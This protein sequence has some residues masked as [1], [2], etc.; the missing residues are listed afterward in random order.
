MY[1][2]VYTHYWLA[3]QSFPLKYLR[4]ITNDSL[5]SIFWLQLLS[6]LKLCLTGTF[7]PLPLLPAGLYPIHH[8]LTLQLRTGHCFSLL[9]STLQDT[10]FSGW[11]SL[12]CVTSYLLFSISLLPPLWHV[13]IRG[14]CVGSATSVVDDSHVLGVSLALVHRALWAHRDS[15]E[16]SVLTDL[17]NLD[18]CIS[19]IQNTLWAIEELF[20]LRFGAALNSPSV[21]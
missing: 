9:Y 7:L 5:K 1:I 12:R 21:M 17:H 11:D 19:N 2:P 18:L 3:T 16:A 8:Q 10:S 13:R 14:V 4:C 20:P 15:P 6:Q